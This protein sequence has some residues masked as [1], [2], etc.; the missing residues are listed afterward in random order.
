MTH[1]H[2]EPHEFRSEESVAV[3]GRP[4]SAT[5][6]FPPAVKRIV[7]RELALLKTELAE[8]PKAAVEDDFFGYGFS[9]AQKADMRLR[10][11]RQAF[12][13]RRRLLE[14]S[15]A[16]P[17]VCELLEV[18]SQTPHDRR[19]A[20]TLLGIKENGVWR[21]PDWQFDMGGPDGVIEGLPEILRALRMGP[22][23]KMR[24]LSE[25]HDL[26]GRSPIEELRVGNRE[27]V[28][29]EAERANAE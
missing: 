12:A 7:D 19:E 21:Y 18:S 3:R 28:L 26:F 23:G 1:R 14:N 22:L 27:R 24:W 13:V 9:P 8:A 15:L 6:G 5:S 16:T 10:A 2:R 17:Q 4:R 25:P 11:L 20:G 29:Y